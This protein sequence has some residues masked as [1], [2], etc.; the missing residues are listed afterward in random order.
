[1]P[2]K[3][4]PEKG[5]FVKGK[6]NKKQTNQGVIT[7]INIY[8]LET[9]DLFTSFS[10]D[11]VNGS[12]LSTILGGKN[13]AF[14]VEAKGFL[15]FSENVSLKD[16]KQNESFEFDIK[17]E[18]FAIG[19]E[20]VMKNIFFETNKY[21]LLETSKTELNYLVNFLKEN[22]NIKL[23]IGGHTDNVG[24]SSSNQLLSEKRAE[25]VK[26][27]LI[28]NGIAS[29][30]LSSKGYGDTKPMLENNSDIN[31]AKNRRTS[32]KIIS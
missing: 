18:P 12:F 13:Y 17:L 28:E 19:K 10:S 9:G 23:E 21:S 2:E 4:K 32:F 6:L 14:E 24:S 25:T 5:S 1:M 7:K 8:D 22:G 31:K 20:F 15:P 30:R 16:L 11:K 3:L 29:S 27:Y 26:I